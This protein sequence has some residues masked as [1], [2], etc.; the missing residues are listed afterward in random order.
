MKRYLD[1]LA[2][3]DPEAAQRLQHHLGE[4]HFQPALFPMEKAVQEIIEALCV[5]ISFGRTLADGIGRMLVRSTP[6]NLDRLRALITW[7]HTND[8]EFHITEASVWLK[9]GC[10]EPE[11]E[12]QAETYRNIVRVLLEQR[13]G[14]VVSWNTWHISDFRTWHGEWHP[15]LFDRLY[16]PKPAYYAIQDELEHPPEAGG[17]L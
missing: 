5:E 3:A 4:I 7:A 8:L 16:N 14:G 17:P 10:T 2:I 9:Q 12:K 15:A 6:E 11:L 1:H 13:A